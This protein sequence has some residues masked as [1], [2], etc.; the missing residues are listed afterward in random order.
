MLCDYVIMNVKLMIC[1]LTEIYFLWNF[2]WISLCPIIWLWRNYRLFMFVLFRY[3][4]NDKHMIAIITCYTIA[5]DHLHM[6]IRGCC[7]QLDWYLQITWKILMI[8]GYHLIHLLYAGQQNQLSLVTCFTWT[9]VQYCLARSQQIKKKRIKAYAYVIFEFCIYF[10][11][12]LSYLFV[13]KA[14]RI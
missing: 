11:I 1:V 10:V 14:F 5:L 3:M 7:D 9:R 12:C 2:K 6:D 8:K 4:T 13:K